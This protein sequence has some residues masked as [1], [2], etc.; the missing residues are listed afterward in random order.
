[1]M[2]KHLI[3]CTISGLIL[4]GC[5]SPLDDSLYKQWSQSPKQSVSEQLASTAQFDLP[6]TDLFAGDVTLD[7]LIAY[8]LEHHPAIHAA[9]HRV[10]QAKHGIDQVTSFDDPKFTL[11]PLGQMAQTADGEVTLMTSLSQKIPLSNKLSIQGDVAKQQVKITQQQLKQTQLSVTRDIKKTY[12]QYQLTVLTGQVLQKQKVLM[13]Q[14]NEAANAAYRAGR[15]DQ[16]DLLRITVEI[17]QLENQILTSNQQQRSAIA[18]LNSLLNRPVSTELKLTPNASSPIN[19]TS[20]EDWQKQAL[21]Q[22]P[23]L[24]VIHIAIDQARKQL[25]LA[26]LKRIPDLTIMLNYAAVED[27]GTAMSADGTDQ[28][29]AGFGINLPI[30]QSKLEAAEKQAIARISELLKLLVSKNNQLQYEIADSYERVQSQNKQNVLYRKTI[31]PQAQQVV[32]SALSQY[33]A[34]RGS[35]LNLIDNWQKLLDLQL[36][37]HRN[38]TLMLQDFAQLQFLTAENQGQ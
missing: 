36:M 33:R 23:S 19:N 34:G 15:S 13:Q 29:Y 38:H 5:Q 21:N 2:L 7:A 18:R 3:I 9:R 35:F 12:W 10:Q 32:D 11:T 31:L 27:G 6:T 14:F 1:M 37:A 16:Q 17:S 24:R 22:S 28:L 4:M 8:A 25:K 26:H 20:L 30:W